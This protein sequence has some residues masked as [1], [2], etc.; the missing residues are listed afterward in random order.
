MKVE[1][2]IRNILRK[3]YGINRKA[4]KI[5]EIVDWDKEK[6]IEVMEQFG[7]FGFRNRT[8]II[9]TFWP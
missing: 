9:S 3:P 7:T 5:C 6:L 4:E 1:E 2:E 8:K